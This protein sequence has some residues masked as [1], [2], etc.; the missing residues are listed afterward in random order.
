MGD[1]N[2]VQLEVYSIRETF[3]TFD[4]DI[5]LHFLSILQLHA[6]ESNGGIAFSCILIEEGHV[7]CAGGANKLGLRSTFHFNFHIKGDAFTGHF[8]GV[9]F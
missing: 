8:E 6:M 9:D 3:N 7:C 1:H 2:V 4:L 5:L